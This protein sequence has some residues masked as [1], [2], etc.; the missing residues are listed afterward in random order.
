MR[1]TTHRIVDPTAP[2][3]TDAFG[4]ALRPLVNATTTVTIAGDR[5]GLF[6]GNVLGGTGVFSGYPAFEAT[7][8]LPPGAQMLSRATTPDGSPV[9]VA[10]R[11]GKGLVI[12]TGLPDLP[13][14]LSHGGNEQDLVSRIWELLA[15]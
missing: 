3:P 8:A 10:A 4:F 14:R 11:V 7:Q 5:I 6:Q 15:P 2:A 12:R 13:S 1:L 9:I